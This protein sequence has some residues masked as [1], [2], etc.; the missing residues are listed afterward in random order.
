M[1]KL[2]CHQGEAVERVLRVLSS[3][4]PTV[5]VAPTGAGKTVMAAAIAGHFGRVL[6]VAHRIEL[7]N[8]AEA[9]V[10]NNVQV[11]SILSA[12]RR[13][14]KRIDLL[15]I[16]EAHRGMASTYRA[17]IDKYRNVPILGLTATPQRTD[18]QGLCD[19][20]S[21]IVQC[22]NVKELVESGYL[23]PYRAFE[24]PDEA[25]RQIEKVRKRRG[26]FEQSAVSRVMCQPRLVGD[27][28]F[29]YK[30]HALGRKAIVFAVGVRHS[31]LLRNA[32]LAAG[33][34]AAHLDGKATPQF[35]ADRL[36]DLRDGRID[37][38]CNVN[39]FTEG[40]DCPPAS[41]VIMARPTLSL[42]LYL[43]C[44][45]RGMRVCEG[46]DNLVILDHAG[47]ISRHGY[48]DDERY[49]QLE[50]ERQRQ[51]REAEVTELDRLLSLGFDSIEAELEE[52]RRQ[53]ELPLVDW[54]P[55][56]E[57]R[58]RLREIGYL[59]SASHYAKHHSIESRRTFLF[60]SQGFLFRRSEAERELKAGIPPKNSITNSACA[61]QVG[62]SRQRIL[63]ILK[64]YNLPHNIIGPIT[65]IPET[66][67][68]EIQHYLHPVGLVSIRQIADDLSVE[69]G[70][71]INVRGL[72]F[73]IQELGLKPRTARGKSWFSPSQV[74]VVRDYYAPEVPTGCVRFAD[75]QRELSVRHGAVAYQMARM[76][77]TP[78]VVRGG[79]YLRQEDA[80]E[81]RKYYAR[82]RALI[83]GEAAAR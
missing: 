4:N 57:L 36:A 27:V 28:V 50:S 7:I 45:G 67:V 44:V 62:I 11:M 29:E 51:K 21:E 75:L 20:F 70:K 8:Q 16:D 41:C 26:D 34:R 39:L 13:G 82:K 55:S 74:A 68:E 77:Y 49:W 12:L 24:A 64:T 63:E 40:W 56:A 33:I 22:S 5:L 80:N 79:V 72:A 37:V 76:R 25:L 15:I 23:V 32:F 6:W 81:I 46:K 18:G 47:N 9:E 3:N 83:P 73:R 52:K 35:R 43:Q 65:W 53:S 48:P 61:R 1:H 78:I 2:F 30:R 42:T 71:T 19:I 10:A 54:M 31:R 69:L 58:R 66:S 14:P 38:L 59:S 17:L 60:G